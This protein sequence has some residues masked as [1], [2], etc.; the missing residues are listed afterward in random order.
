M[1]D[2][3]L[4]NL[5]GIATQGIVQQIGGGR[6]TANYI[7][8]SRTLGLLREHAA[9]WMPEM[10]LA[11]SGE[12]VHRDGDS[13]GGYLMIRFRHIDGRETPAAPQAIMDYRN[14]AIPLNK[15]TAR[16]ITD[17]HR[18]GVC[19]AA[20]MFFG[21][22]YELWAK[23]PLETGYAGKDNCGTITEDQPDVPAPPT[24]TAPPPTD[25][26]PAIES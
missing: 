19:L 1:A 22:A 24:S 12:Y 13:V 25:V 10:L 17:T 3:A 8:W 9:G 18:R 21:L 6:Y 4:P 5:A 15:I 16:D 23:M 20:C 11:P 2:K 7:N 14:N 26:P